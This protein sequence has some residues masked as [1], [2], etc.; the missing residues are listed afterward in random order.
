MNIFFVRNKK[1]R[2]NYSLEEFTNNNLSTLDLFDDNSFVILKGLA[3]F[4]K[5]NDPSYF[6]KAFNCKITKN[7]VILEKKY[8]S[9][10]SFRP[11]AI[12]TFSK[13]KFG[14]RFINVRYTIKKTSVY[15]LGIVEVLI[16]S[17]IFKMGI[18]FIIPCILFLLLW[19]LL[20]LLSFY[21]NYFSTKKS[22]KELIIL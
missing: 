20:G 2:T 12:F 11:I 7:K 22:I 13:N 18:V 3:E 9:M 8:Y 5:K 16:L 14:E 4:K 15:F 6:D 1:I 21:S 19:Y 17:M 10:N